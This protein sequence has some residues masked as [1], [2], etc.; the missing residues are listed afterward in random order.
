MGRIS[1]IFAKTGEFSGIKT[2]RAVSNLTTKAWLGG[3]WHGGRRESIRAV[4]TAVVQGD[5]E[6]RKFFGGLLVVGM[7][8]GMV[9][10]GGGE[11]PAPSAS[12]PPAA[13]PTAP[14][15]EAA[16][17]EAAPAEAAPAEAA[18]AEAAPAEAA[19][20]PEAKPEGDAAPAP[21]PEAKPEGDAAPAPAPEAKPEGEAKPE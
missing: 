11:A 16:P 2:V 17:A 10:C 21:A 5:V 15:A 4:E 19:P 1:K 13:A 8:F 6:M 12:T 3:S 9:G 20:A 18:P 7:M 14:P